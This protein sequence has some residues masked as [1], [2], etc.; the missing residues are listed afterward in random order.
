MVPL[1]MA[2][3]APAIVIPLPSVLANDIGRDYCR[4][5]PG[6]LRNP[7]PIQLIAQDGVARDLH[8]RVTPGDGRG[9]MICQ[10]VV[11]NHNSR[12]V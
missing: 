6:R 11:R 12:G 5:N 9:A 10:Y 3:E 1:V 8:R 2:A 7:Y 4:R